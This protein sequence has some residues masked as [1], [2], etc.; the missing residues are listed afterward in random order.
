MPYLSLCCIVK[1]EDAHLREWINYHLLAGV[2]HF[3][4][5]DDGS[6]VPVAELLDDYVAEGLVTVH[7]PP[8]SAT[9][10]DAYNDCIERYREGHSRWIGFIDPDEF[11]AL[12][13][14]DDLRIFLTRY[15]D[16]AGLAVSWVM[17]G[18]NGHVTRP[19][20]GTLA[21]Y[22]RRL[23]LSDPANRHVKSIVQPDKV[24]AAINGHSFV[25]YPGRHC[26]NEDGFPVNGMFSYHTAEHI[27]LNHYYF[28]SQ[29]D[30]AEKME[31]GDVRVSPEHEKVD[32]FRWAHF[33]LQAQTPD[34]A[35]DTIR[36]LATR[37][38]RLG[39][40][41]RPAMMKALNQSR[42][43]PDLRMF[44]EEIARAAGRN[45]VEAERISGIAVA[46][47]PDDASLWFTRARLL[48]AVDQLDE[49]LMAVKRSVR[50]HPSPEAFAELVSIYLDMGEDREA[51]KT[52]AYLKT[53]ISTDWQHFRPVD[54]RLELLLAA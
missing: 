48:R 7:R 51:H 15:E 9:Q 49:A 19:A 3:I 21:N 36:P 34:E 43:S 45:L 23:P 47:H 54:S 37:L 11:L 38:L 22:P 1:N 31:R 44:G 25:Y 32:K 39:R 46:Y 5:Y 8:A 4:I 18:S 27:Q 53:R 17:H 6:R 28:R 2:E 40:R 41:T 29:Q 12:R 30:F 42:V 16:H 33:F 20:G 14:G 13:H 24:V 10:V 35:D 26:V 52:L 50:I